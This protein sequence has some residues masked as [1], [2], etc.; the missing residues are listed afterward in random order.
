MRVEELE[1]Y[2]TEGEK[3]PLTD[4]LAVNDH[5]ITTLSSKTMKF[6]LHLVFVHNIIAVTDIRIVHRAHQQSFD[7]L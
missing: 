2:N 3:V 4:L 5:M 7:C 1:Y 6:Q